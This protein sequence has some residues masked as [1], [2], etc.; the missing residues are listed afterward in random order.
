[1]SSSLS[2]FV[3]SP[4]HATTPAPTRFGFAQVGSLNLYRFNTPGG[5]QVAYVD[6]GDWKVVVPNGEVRDLMESDEAYATAFPYDAREEQRN[7]WVRNELADNFAT[8]TQRV[9]DL[10]DIIAQLAA[11]QNA[12]APA[13]A[14]PAPSISTAPIHVMADKD[15]SIIKP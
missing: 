13:P 5:V 7:V 4:A 9:A 14:A 8:L 12:P 11:Q 6:Q 15:G 10:S 2:T 1:M 3:G